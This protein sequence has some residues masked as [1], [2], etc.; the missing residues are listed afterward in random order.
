MR[1]VGELVT[2]AISLGANDMDASDASSSSSSSSTSTKAAV[3]AVLELGTKDKPMTSS[4]LATISLSISSAVVSASTLYVSNRASPLTAIKRSPPC[5]SA[6]DVNAPAAASKSSSSSSPPFV[7]DFP[8]TSGADSTEC[9]ADPSRQTRTR[10]PSPTTAKITPLPPT[11]GFTLPNLTISDFY[12]QYDAVFD[13]FVHRRRR[14]G[15]E[16]V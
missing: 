9:L 8:A 14:P 12:A 13:G 10:P 15:L 11:G 3:A 16:R 6:H 7:S 2:T 5:V 1:T 4:V